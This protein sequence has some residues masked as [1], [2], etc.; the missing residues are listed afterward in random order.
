MYAV[1]VC[2]CNYREKGRRLAAMR[3]AEARHRAKEAADAAARL[4]A[5][6]LANAAK[7]SNVCYY[8]SIQQETANSSYCS[9]C[10]MHA[11]YLAHCSSV[12]TAVMCVPCRA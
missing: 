1:N 2:V 10:I 5:L 12:P 8:T 11:A 6:E 4:Q 7:V 9:V 3:A